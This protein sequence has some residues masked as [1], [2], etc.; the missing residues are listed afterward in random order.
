MASFKEMKRP[1]QVGVAMP[2]S[3]TIVHDQN[4][5]V[6]TVFCFLPLPL[7]SENRSPTG[8]WFDAGLRI[9]L[10]R[11]AGYSNTLTLRKVGVWPVAKI[12]NMLPICVGR[13]VSDETYEVLYHRIHPELEGF[14][15]RAFDR[16]AVPRSWV[17]CVGPE[18]QA[19]QVAECRTDVA[20]RRDAQMEPESDRTGSS[21]G[22]RPSNSEQNATFFSEQEASQREVR[23]I[24]KAL[25]EVGRR[26]SVLCGA[27][28]HLIGFQAMAVAYLE[29]VRCCSNN[30]C[31]AT[32]VLDLLPDST[33]VVEHWRPTLK[34]LFARL[35]VQH[36]C[37]PVMWICRR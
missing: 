27:P 16:P 3:T 31:E 35:E 26:L 11:I 12:G 19:H 17:V 32:C 1:P 5:T 23:V 9:L 20:D 30:S 18:P 22:K 29:A 28:V 36:E 4:P 15:T 37:S 24:F 7:P 10:S 34:P 21:E 13:T 8:K 33:L 6:G 14:C 2:I 25:A